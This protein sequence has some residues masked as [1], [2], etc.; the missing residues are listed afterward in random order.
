MLPSIY[1]I[2]SLDHT[3]WCKNVFKKWIAKMEFR[4]K[5][6]LELLGILEN[7]TVNFM[8]T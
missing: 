4:L 3:S 6:I 2:T 1:Y 5:E 7:P 8:Q